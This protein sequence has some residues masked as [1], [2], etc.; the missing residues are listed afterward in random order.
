MRKCTI[1]DGKQGGVLVYE[2]GQG[3]IE[4]CD[5]ACNALAGVEI[6]TGGNSQIQGCRIHRNKYEAIWI[7]EK[8]QGTIKNCDLT[9][10]TR[11]AWDIGSDCRVYRS[12]NK[13]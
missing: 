13:E 8:G 1:H 3:T 2:N 11:G 9:G 6:K 7:Y 10:N 5:I 12:G 4:D